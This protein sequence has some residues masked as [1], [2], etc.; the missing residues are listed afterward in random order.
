MEHQIFESV[1]GEN[2]LE[3]FHHNIAIHS[4]VKLGLVTGVDRGVKI[5]G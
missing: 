1:W 5:N 4:V 3:Q 2:V